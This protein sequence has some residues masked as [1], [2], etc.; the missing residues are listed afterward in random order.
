LNSPHNRKFILATLGSII[1]TTRVL[2]MRGRGDY[3]GGPA[4]RGGRNNGRGR[5]TAPKPARTGTIAAIGAYLDL[6]PGR[7]INPS[8]V[9]TWM[10]KVGE[11]I[12]ANYDF[13]INQI[14][15]PDGTVGNYP[16][17]VEPPDPPEDATRVVLKKWEGRLAKYNKDRQAL[18][19]DRPKV[20]GNMIGQISE[21]SKNRIRET[22]TGSEA[23]ETHDPRLLL[24]AIISTHLT[25][26]RLGAEHNLFKVEQAF[27][28]YVMQ[29]HDT[30]TYYYQRMRALVSGVREAKLRAGIDEEAA[31]DNDARQVQLALKFTTGLNDSYNTYKQYYHD[32]VRDWPLTLSD[33]FHEA[34]KFVPRR[35]DLAG[36]HGPV[37]HVNA[38]A[39]RGRGRGRGR[40]GGRNPGGRDSGRGRYQPGRGNQPQR[41]DADS[42]WR[43]YGEAEYGTRKGECHLCGE[44]GHYSFE[45]RGGQGRQKMGAGGAQEPTGAGMQKG[46]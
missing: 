9:T 2:A 25:D 14:F 33:A 44:A 10:T 1:N 46:K 20:Y 29:R 34:S 4:N 26:N 11:Y 19:T 6:L 41:D 36:D 13:Q 40:N 5:S 7:D 32:S 24:Q 39:M 27:N 17:I 43:N 16:I 23:M 22:V 18:E 8:I 35:G 38:F 3:R 37:G 12:T 42:T 28:M 31:A 15:G 21:A 45:C 30:L